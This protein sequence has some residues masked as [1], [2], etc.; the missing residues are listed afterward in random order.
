[1]LSGVSLAKVTVAKEV[2]RLLGELRSDAAY[3]RLVT[4]DGQSLHRDVRIAMLRALWDHL[5]REPTWGAF[6]RAVTGPD[7]VMAARVGD[8]PADRLTRESDRRLSA[9]LGRVLDRPEPEARID[10]LRRAAYLSVS[11]P[12]RTFLT[13]CS[14]RLRSIYDDEVQAAAQAILQ[15]STEVDMAR[16][17]GLLAAAMDDAR[18]LHVAVGSLL[19][20][21]V[22]ARAVWIGA[23]RAA[24][25]VLARDP[26]HAVL[27]VR[28]AAAAME[29]RELAG[30]LAALGE[31]GALGADALE[32]C[33]AA[34]EALPVVDLWALLERLC[35]SPSPEARRV[36]VWA[37]IR[38][39][40][41]DRGWA[42]ER[43]EVL[44]ALQRD[45][46]PAVSGAALAVFP[47]REM[48][49]E[50]R[51]IEALPA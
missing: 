8:I 26:R 41:P 46:S 38:D 50:Q 32:A 22:K 12:E 10:L 6:E 19:S 16:L 25:A 45:P 29:A 40:G 49:Q 36:A 24:E 9:L 23:A 42:P 31:S 39:A 1:V 7:F 5:D 35:V 37:L 13:A 21:N 11:D 20:V 51:R 33:R 28:C 44:A 2:V 43:L 15:R 47:P 14:A 4:L 27:R 48:A 17:P 34:V 3:D 30:Y 18:C